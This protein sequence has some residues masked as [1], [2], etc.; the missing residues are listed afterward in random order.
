MITLISIELQKIFRK[1]RS[2]I[3]FIAIGLMTA[4]VQFALYIS[5]D[6][7]IKFATRGLQ[8]NFEFVGNLFNGYLVAYF[9]LQALFI[10]IPFLIVLVGGDLFAGEATAGTYRMI[11]TRPI[12]R[13][14]LVT[15][16][17]LAG[18]VY[19]NILLLWLMFVSFGASVLLFGTGELIIAR[20]NILIFASN[21][22]LWRFT[23]AYAFAVLSMTTV[24]S[25]SI[26][27]SSMVE[28]AVGPIIAT[29]AVIIVFLIISAIPVDLLISLRPYFFT[30][31]LVQ[32]NEF[33][34]DP[35]DAK[36]IVNSGLILFAH[37]AGLY[38]LTAYLFIKKDIM[39]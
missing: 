14:K 2:Y 22:V 31:H 11:L 37:I 20:G 38:L 36:E 23:A 9:I 34:G 32:W 26:F 28:N 18:F 19:T 4:I 33:F 21:D 27:F 35:V 29:M 15:A 6:N 13:F 39:S 8:D 3:G 17:F 25:L 10:H 24:I 16:K 30:T 7:Y 5:K 12:S 1:W